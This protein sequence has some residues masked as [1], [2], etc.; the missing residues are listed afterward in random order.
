MIIKT[1]IL[2]I[3]LACIFVILIITL[4]FNTYDFN[5]NY[6]FGK[7]KEGMSI[8][9]CRN[10]L[11]NPDKSQYYDNQV[12]DVYYYFPVG[13]ARFFYSKNNK[14]LTRSWKTDFD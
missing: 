2:N 8:S 11:G 4:I 13:E 10:I 1:A 9:D 7:I 6:K 3:F 5:N 14:I 12:M